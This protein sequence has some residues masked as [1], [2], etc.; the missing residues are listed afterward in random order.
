MKHSKSSEITKSSSG[1]S[2]RKSGARGKKKSG[3]KRDD[4]SRSPRSCPSP[5]MGLDLSLTGTGL[6][7][8]DGKKVLRKR[9]YKTRPV[10]PGDGLRPRPQG[11]VAP[12]QFVGDDE[13]RIEWLKRKVILAVKQFGICFVVIEDHAF[14]A[15]GRGKTQLAELQGVVK[16]AL[17]RHEVAYVK[18]APTSIKK[19]ATGDGR[20]QKID[21]I[22]AAKQ[23][24]RS[25]SDSDTADAF[26][27][28]KL[29][30]DEYDSLTEE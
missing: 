27:C 29:A 20:A 12:D 7:V 30:W 23:H 3:R 19:F 9:R 2:G 16:N 1:A 14:G 21:L 24:D 13:E 25:I 6:V 4:S 17:M 8:W 10:P 18:K 22:Y 5:V 28:A 26:W 11:Q 15:K